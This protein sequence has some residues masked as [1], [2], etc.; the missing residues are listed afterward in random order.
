MSQTFTSA[1]RENLTYHHAYN[2][3]VCTRRLT[4]PAAY[5][6]EAFP[7]AVRNVGMSWATANLWMYNFVLALT[8]PLLQTSITPQG[9]FG[10]YAAWCF[11]LWVLV[12]LFLPE[13]KG[14]S[15]PQRRHSQTIRTT[16]STNLCQSLNDRVLVF[17]APFQDSCSHS[18]QN[19]PSRNS[20]KFFRSPHGNM[21]LIKS[22]TACIMSVGMRS[23]TR[24]RSR[25][26]HSTK[27]QRILTRRK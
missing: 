22:E 20:T 27:G 7:T 2:V 14:Q 4:F 1:S 8:F 21:P 11:I 25:L 5:S 12:I 6:A 10:F 24:R 16:S 3:M 13:T 26:L 19:S 9:A 18:K 17:V 15:L 23:S